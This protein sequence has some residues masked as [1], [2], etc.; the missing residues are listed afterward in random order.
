[1]WFFAFKNRATF[2]SI[3]LGYRVTR[4]GD[5][6]AENFAGICQT[7]TNGRQYRK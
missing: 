7:K 4:S 3:R 2:Y 6:W 1:M 5:I